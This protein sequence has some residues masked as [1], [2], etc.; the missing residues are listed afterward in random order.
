MQK[1][2]NWFT[3]VEL[4]V[5]ITILAILWTIAFISLQWYTR[6]ARDSWRITNLSK[7]NRYLE[8]FKI[9]NYL[10]YPDDYVEL[11]ASWTVILFQWNFW[12]WVWEKVKV[13]DLPKD[14]LDDT[15]Y[16]YSIDKRQKNYQ[17][18]T[19]LEKPS[20]LSFWVQKAS[21]KWQYEDRYPKVMWNK[22]GII[23]DKENT[24]IQ[25]IEEIKTSSWLD[26]VNTNYYY[27]SIISDGYSISWS[28]SKLY[29]S[30]PTSSCKRII[31]VY[32]KVK[33]IYT[34]NP[35]WKDIN[36]YCDSR[37]PNSNFYD[38]IEDW[39]ME[40]THWN[41][42]KLTSNVA[43]TQEESHS[44][45]YSLR[46][47][48]IYDYT[49]NNLTFID[50]TKEYMLEWYF[51]W[52]T[53]DGSPTYFYY[54]FA[55]YDEDFK[56]ITPNRVNLIPWTET[57]LSQEVK[58]TDRAI[59]FY[60]DDTIY[61]NW[62]NWIVYHS[63]VAFEID[64]SWAYNDL[65]NSNL[66]WYISNQYNTSNIKSLLSRSG[67]NCT[68]SYHPNVPDGRVWKNYPAWTKIR[69]HRSWWTYNYKVASNAKLSWE[70]EY[71]SW[72]VKWESLYWID[73]NYFRRWT[74]FV[75]ILILPNRWSRTVDGVIYSNNPNAILYADDLKLTIKK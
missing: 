41:N 27:N 22:I 58:K 5:V 26:I 42:W 39:D 74:R 57:T 8:V 13:W 32:W 12:K 35:K 2:K 19:F 48:K 67:N 56:L 44:G 4:I 53:T 14:S 6:D 24:P 17:I 33:W 34:I 62:Y 51:K 70:W 31:D 55:E 9:D 49:S 36:V 54:W 45:Q 61:N 23:L 29:A 15:Y 66:S 68:I 37:Y 10:A 25:N 21:A 64:D 43:K 28:W 71:F 11:R 18:M 60:C 52:I 38:F 47:E 75:K 7:I 30:N 73:N 63:L 72:S 69:L 40:D 50:P 46:F 16:T 59:H 20:L 65:P 1:T 3:L